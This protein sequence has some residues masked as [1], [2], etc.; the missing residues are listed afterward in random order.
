MR[1][2]DFLKNNPSK[3]KD[4]IDGMLKTK[5]IGLIAGDPGSGKTFFT[6][7]VAYHIAYGANFLNQKTNKGA[8]LIIDREN[9]E[10]ELRGR[11]RKIKKA[12]E[13]EGYSDKAEVEIQHYPCFLLNDKRMWSEI[14]KVIQDI[15]P[16]LI[17]IDHLRA[18]HT[19]NENSSQDMEKIANYLIELSNI[20]DS[21]IMVV[22]HFN[23]NVAGSFLKRLRGSIQ[24]Y[25]RSEFA[26]EVR[27]LSHNAGLLESFGVIPQPRKEKNI[28]PFRVILEEDDKH[29]KFKYGG[30]YQPVEDPVLD[31]IAHRIAHV[32]IKDKEVYTVEKVKGI[33]AGMASDRQVREA[34]YTLEQKSIVSLTR[35]GKAHKFEYMPKTDFCP[36]CQK[37]LESY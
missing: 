16:V 28:S 32:F 11:I 12:I 20:C 36:W 21:T 33:L 17:T 3:A 6:L 14:E 24:I 30:E 4:L 27:A 2:E 23:K 1:D 5:R 34:L 35:M 25:A 18:F 8:I 15:R 19:L 7:G 26:F 31:T 29:I 13:E 10:E 22:H 9:S 37:V